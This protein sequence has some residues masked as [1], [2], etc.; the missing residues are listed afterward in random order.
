MR[1]WERIFPLYAPLCFSK[2]W[3]GGCREDYLGIRLLALHLQL[4]LEE[5]RE[6]LN[7]SGKL[8]WPFQVPVSLLGLTSA[9]HLRHCL[10]SKQSG[11]KSPKSSSVLC[12]SSRNAINREHI[13]LG[14]SI[15]FCV[16]LSSIVNLSMSPSV[17]WG[18]HNSFILMFNKIT[19]IH[20]PETRNFLQSV[21]ISIQVV[22][23]K[24]N[25]DL[26]S[27]TKHPVF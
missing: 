8:P 4:S 22:R 15:W 20:D 16:S 11:H 27:G 3:V 2:Q 14:S 12:L 13:Y 7:G 26:A 19:G 25:L 24:E 9:D 10:P 21:K 18:I 23:V 1:G 5:F 6:F 17:T